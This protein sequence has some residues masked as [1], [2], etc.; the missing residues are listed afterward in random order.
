MIQS[1]ESEINQQTK[2]KVFKRLQQSRP[3]INGEVNKHDNEPSNSSGQAERLAFVR[4]N[5]DY[6]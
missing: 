4:S 2:N 5:R 1:H 6:R 3:V